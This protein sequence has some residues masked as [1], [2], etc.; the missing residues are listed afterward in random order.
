MT[1]YPEPARYHYCRAG[2]DARR[3]AHI[4]WAHGTGVT[5]G[6]VIAEGRRC[7]VCGR[8]WILPVVEGVV[9]AEKGR[10]L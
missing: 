6:E 7:W 4:E 9:R 5:A 10:V 8:T 3:T 2:H 1:L